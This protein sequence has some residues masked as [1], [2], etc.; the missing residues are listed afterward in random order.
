MTETT[1]I[2]AG[3]ELACELLNGDC[4]AFVECH[5][6]P[7]A[8]LSAGDQEI[9][10]DYTAAI[11]AIT[12][13]AGELQRLEAERDAL[14][15]KLAE[16]ERAEPVA[17][18][19]HELQGTG[20]RHLHFRRRPNTLRDDVV[21]P[22]WTEL[23][24]RPAPATELRRERDELAAKYDELL[25]AL[26]GIGRALGIEEAD[27]SPY[28]ITCG[29]LAMANRLA[30]IEAQE[31]VA[32][33][34]A[35]DA[36]WLAA[37]RCATMYKDPAEDW[38]VPL[39]AHPAPAAAPVLAGR[40]ELLRTVAQQILRDIEATGQLMEWSTPLADAL[41]AAPER[42]E[43]AMYEL[44]GTAGTTHPQTVTRA[45]CVQSV[46]LVAAA[47]T[48]DG[49]ELYTRHDAPVPMADNEHLY[50]AAPAQSQPCR[51]CGLDCCQD[52]VICPRGER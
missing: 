26:H 40:V 7:K 9:A 6:V 27:R 48:Q 16:I 30:A 45:S 50:A 25:V 21:A 5:I 39:Y 31:P 1:T 3:L 52:R 34:R 41:S 2:T 23:I 10:D 46:Y 8:G 4:A 33:Y 47:L 29:V 32:H 28:S 49:Q 22:V 37:G 36:E 38:I 44:R 42:A 24:A 35:S 14:A 17:W 43:P 12:G 13:A 19:E 11:A 18:I 20:L 15:A 51:T